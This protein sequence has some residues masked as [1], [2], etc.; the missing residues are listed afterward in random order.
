[1][2]VLVD[3]HKHRMPQRFIMEPQDDIQKNVS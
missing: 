1:M 2:D 3:E